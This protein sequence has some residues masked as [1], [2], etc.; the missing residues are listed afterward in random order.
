MDDERMDEKKTFNH[1]DIDND[2]EDDEPN[3]SLPEFDEEMEY[4]PFA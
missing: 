2:I 4:H 1:V 3:E